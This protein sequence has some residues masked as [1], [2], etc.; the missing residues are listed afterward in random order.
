MKWDFA[1]RHLQD[2]Y[3][4]GK[5]RKYPFIDK[6]LARKFVE[7]IGRI[8]SAEDINDLRTPPSMHFEALN[9]F[10]NRFSI[11]IDLKHRLEFEIDFEDEKRTVG[12]VR[13]ITVSKHYE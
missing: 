1:D 13:V 2:V 10:E 9:G 12:S 7:R 6:L 11:R 3:E 5:S 8:E 4:K